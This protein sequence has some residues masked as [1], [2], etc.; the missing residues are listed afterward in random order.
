M[1]A[2]TTLN[3]S[4]VPLSEELKSTNPVI[5]LPP[6]PATQLLLDSGSTSRIEAEQ[7]FEPELEISADPISFCR[8]T[9]S[10]HAETLLSVPDFYDSA[11]SKKQPWQE[12]QTNFGATLGIHGHYRSLFSPG[13]NYQNFYDI[14]GMSKTQSFYES[15]PAPPFYSEFGNCNETTFSP[16][17]D[18]KQ[19]KNY[20]PFAVESRCYTRAYFY[21]AA[22]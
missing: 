2:N 20:R 11:Y 13:G 21:G 18:G 14:F 9:Y 15:N 19:F 5:E 12:S 8:G 16:P 3:Y 22:R 4:S 1:T 10:V 7:K 17:V 6:E